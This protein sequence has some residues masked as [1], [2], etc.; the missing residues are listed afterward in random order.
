MNFCKI[1][2]A[3]FF[4]LLLISAAPVI[5][6]A[7]IIEE[8]QSTLE[9]GESEEA[10]RGYAFTEHE[11][12]EDES[13]ED[14]YIEDFHSKKL[15]DRFIKNDSDYCKTDFEEN[16]PE[17]ALLLREMLLF[18]D[19]GFIE[20][21]GFNYFKYRLKNLIGKFI[22]NEYSTGDIDRDI[23]KNMEHFLTMLQFDLSIYVDT[24]SGIVD[25]SESKLIKLFKSFHSFCEKFDT[26]KEN[27][28]WPSEWFQG[29][30]DDFSTQQKK[31]N[32]FCDK[33][34]IQQFYKKVEEDKVQTK[35]CIEQIKTL[36]QKNH[37]AQTE[38]KT[39]ETNESSIGKTIN[40]R[41]IKAIKFYN[42]YPWKRTLA[43]AG[44][45]DF[46]S[47][48][49]DFLKLVVLYDKV[50]DHD[51][52]LC[53]K[54]CVL[55]K[56]LYHVVLNNPFFEYSSLSENQKKMMKPDAETTQLFNKIPNPSSGS[57]SSQED[58]EP[59]GDQSLNSVL[60]KRSREEGKVEEEGEGKT[61]EKRQKVTDKH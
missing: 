30:A 8:S 37:H 28:Q 13:I 16:H 54:A 6:G 42:R 39:I 56:G 33:Q 4:L 31:F 2:R 29:V 61:E 55:L 47:Y 44:L 52:E 10:E 49:N 48:S 51:K 35:E 23:H 11:Y 36:Y 22:H 41:F 53:N 14:Q 15:V 20:L 60:G 7:E 19:G 46:F 17:Y 5:N 40:E 50:Q 58:R 18:L 9:V 32:D 3:Y 21:T 1:N 26:I 24:K 25:D 34:L 38:N 57:V 43:I 45:R 12:D 27:G 59:H